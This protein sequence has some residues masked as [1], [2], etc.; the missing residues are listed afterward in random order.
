MI[1]AQAGIWRPK[2]Q[3]GFAVEEES[4]SLL[5][6]CGSRGDTLFSAR[7]ISTQTFAQCGVA[8]GFS[9]TLDCPSL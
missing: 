8:L 3:P 6:W 1:S 2:W 5:D 9:S 7:G 4:Q